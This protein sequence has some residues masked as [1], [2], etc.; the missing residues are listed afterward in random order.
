MGT[1][2]V[3]ARICAEGELRPWHDLEQH[4]AEGEGEQSRAGEAAGSVQGGREG[5]EH[6]GGTQLLRA[7]SGFPRPPARIT[8]FPPPA[9]STRIVPSRVCRRGAAEAARAGV[10]THAA[11][12]TQLSAH[13]RAH[14]AAA[15]AVASAAPPPPQ[16][17]P[18]TGLQTDCEKATLYFCFFPV[19]AH[20]CFF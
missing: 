3:L 19:T 6:I 7:A 11:R 4:G 15:F 1:H 2:S 8:A 12:H 5:Q 16:A 9:A 13:C 20:F 10:L 14:A 17:A 18:F